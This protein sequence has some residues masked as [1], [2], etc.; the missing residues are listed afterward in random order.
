MSW[1]QAFIDYSSSGTCRIY[2]GDFE[3]ARTAPGT[4]WDTIFIESG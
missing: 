4:D 1:N 3:A 2:A